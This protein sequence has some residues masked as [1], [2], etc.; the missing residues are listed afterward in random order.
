M[1][2]RK[3][4][5]SKHLSGPITVV[6]SVLVQTLPRLR[7]LP[8]KAVVV[9]HS[10]SCVW[11]FVTLWTATHQTFLSFA[12]SLSLL[13]IHVHWV[14]DAIRT[15]QPL[16][17]P[18][19]AL[20]FSQHQ[21]LFPWIDSLH[22]VA[23]VL[24]LQFQHQSFQWIFRVDFFR[25]DWL[26]LLAVQDSLKTLLQHQSLKALIPQCS[27]FF[28]VQLSHPY[29]TTRKI[30]ALSIPTFV[31]KVMSL[32]F[33]T[34]SRFAIAFLPRSKHLLISWLQSSSTVILEPKKM[35]SLTG[36]TFFPS[37]CHEVMVPDAMI[38]VFWMLSFEPAVSLSSFTFIKRIFS[39]SL[40]S[41]IN[42][43]SSVYLRLL[44]F[45]LTILILSW[46]S[47]SP[48]FHMMYSA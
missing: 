15:S 4:P 13:K 1:E 48:A 17:A 37:L 41:A 2:K 9:V 40:L 3:A 26:D 20:S 6:E 29:V 46:A 31:S 38:L 42:V 11:L 18:S 24:E 10:L 23:K 47:F 39:S 30:I 35:K 44:I 34:L 19:L 45:L 27:A 16:L 36:S 32:L 33:N 43:V 14:N 8:L 5:A 21:D 22:Q 25:I 12:I 7:S 28:M